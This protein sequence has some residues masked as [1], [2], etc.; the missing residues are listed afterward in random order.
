MTL[1]RVCFVTNGHRKEDH[2]PYIQTVKRGRHEEDA[3]I[4]E[5]VR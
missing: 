4:V 2:I 1:Q 3:S 5:E